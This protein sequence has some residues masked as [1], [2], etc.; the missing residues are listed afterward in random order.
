[1]AEAP[2]IRSVDPTVP[3]W[4]SNI[5]TRLLKKVPQERFQSALDLVWAL[6]QAGSTST[7]PHEP[8]ARSLTLPWHPRTAAVAAAVAAL[9]LIPAAGWLANSRSAIERSTPSLAQFTIALPSDIVLDSAPVVSPDSRHIAFVGKGDTDTQLFVRTLGERQAGVIAGTSGASQPFWSPDSTSLGYF[10]RGQLMKVSWR[11]GAPVAL[12]RAPMGRGGAWSPS[13]FITFA[14]DVILAG[15][16]RVPAAGGEITPATTLEVSRGDTSHWWPVHLADGMHFLYFAR[17]MVDERI[18]VFVGRADRAP[19]NGDPLLFRSDS[20]VVYAPLAGG[21]NGVLLSAVDGRMEVRRINL[22]T[23]AVSTDARRLDLSTGGSTLFHPVMLSASAEVLAFADAA[24]SGNRLEVIDRNGQ[25]LRRWDEAEAQNWPRVSPDGGRVARQRVDALKNSPDIWVDDLER[26]TRVLVTRSAEPDIQ[27][28]WSPDGRYLAFVTGGL[29][30]R[31]GKRA[32]NIAAA[33]GTGIVRTMPCPGEYCEPTDWHPDSDTMLVNVVDARGWDVWTVST[34]D[35]GKAEPLLTESYSER[36]AR[37][38]PD[39][40]WIAYASGESGRS[41]VSVRSVSAPPK[42]VPLSPG[43]GAQPVWRRDGRELFYVEPQGRLQSVPVR[44]RG[45][46]APE[47][48]LAAA[49]P[50]PPVGFGHWGTQYDISPDGNRI[51][52]LRV[53]DDPAPREIHVV[54]GWQALIE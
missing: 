53:N 43:G 26:G 40:R 22:K 23:L 37:F 6:E 42:R 14:P 17:S 51:Y 49:L 39:G 3:L 31:P 38:S 16:S 34:R 54:M 29:P 5:V 11:G 20:N 52:M 27:P 4:L 28:V 44:L 18:G 25:R 32:L 30:G 41:E 33:D 21:A 15:L 7:V 46:G 45:S 13:G 48:G 24:P 19:S 50:V 1:V 9:A 12:A 10:A 35:G 8:G 47:F 36:D 2:D